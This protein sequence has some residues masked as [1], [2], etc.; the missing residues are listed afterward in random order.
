MSIEHVESE[1]LAAL[2][3]A[4]LARDPLHSQF[5]QRAISNLTPE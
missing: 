3:E 4:I 5:L 1:R 2:A